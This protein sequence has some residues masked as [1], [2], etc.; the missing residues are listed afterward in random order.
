MDPMRFK[1]RISEWNDDRGFGFIAP[2]E[3]GARVF[4]HIKSFTERSS[5]PEIGKAVTYELASDER[6]RPRANQVRYAVAGRPSAVTEPSAGS[7]LTRA[8]IGSSTFFALLTALVLTGLAPWWVLAWYFTLSVVTYV[9]YAWDKVS[10]RGGHWRTQESTLNGLALLGG[11]PGAW[12]AQYSMRHKSRKASFQS[13]FWSA[14]LLNVVALVILL[15]FDIEALL[16][17]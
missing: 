17:R 8:R 1:G 5:R 10:A 7:N 13:A 14:T 16:P 2:S 3:G 4:C 11:W 6:G 12:I 15:V 9:A